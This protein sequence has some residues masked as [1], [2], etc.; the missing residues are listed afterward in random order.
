MSKDF[1]E[2]G[3]KLFSDRLLGGWGNTKRSI[4]QMK[5]LLAAAARRPSKNQVIRVTNNVD[6]GISD[7]EFI[8]FRA[9]SRSDRRG[10]PF[11]EISATPQIK[12]RR[13]FDNL[14]RTLAPPQACLHALKLQTRRRAV[15]RLR[16]SPFNA[17]NELT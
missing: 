1:V 5:D 15:R 13:R 7:C 10:N 16:R 17:K 6:N 12:Y 8:A 9:C 14:K 3:Q 11:V 4:R 2:S